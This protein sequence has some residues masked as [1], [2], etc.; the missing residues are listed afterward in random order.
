[1]RSIT[2]SLLL[3]GGLIS[4]GCAGPK[5]S[6]KPRVALVMKSLANEFFK[7]M[8]D[9]ARA[10]QAAHPDRYQL[11][12]VGIK[13]E[14]DVA[15]Q[16]RLVEQMMAA[17]VDALVIA[18]AD[19]KAMV[20]VCKR[21]QDAGIVVVNIDNELDASVL[22]EKGM[23]VPFV[24]PDNAAGARKVGEYLAARL[25][26]GA[27]VAILEG[28]PAA[29]NAVERKR[30]FEEAMAAAGIQVVAS[31]S[32]SWETAK[33]N[34]VAAA[35]ITEIPD[36]A[37]FLCANDSMALGAVAALK[38]AGREHAVLVVGYDDISAAKELLRDGRMLATA[39]QHADQLAV[40]GIEYALEMLETKTAPENRETPVDLVTAQ[41]LGR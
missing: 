38:A 8:E 13:D 39:D 19:S 15:G 9:G 1:L 33:A 2:V 31:Q 7:T 26:K 11:L 17:G 34:Q 12:A 40:Y 37:A 41:S 16:I 30:G 5:P 25:P 28:M 14:Q 22:A 29:F 24:G 6:G 20:S 10:H 35:L 27:K 3:T 32:G 4:L 21:A 23:Q 36:L 18:P